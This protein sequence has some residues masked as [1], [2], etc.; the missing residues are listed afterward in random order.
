MMWISYNLKW[1][2]IVNIIELIS[3]YQI[4]GQFLVQ[5]FLIKGEIKGWKNDWH[6]NDYIGGVR[7]LWHLAGSIQTLAYHSRTAIVWAVRAH[8]VYISRDVSRKVLRGMWNILDCLRWILYCT[9]WK[10]ICFFFHFSICSGIIKG[11]VGGR[12]IAQYPP[13]SKY[14]P[15]YIEC[16]FVTE[17]V[18]A[19]SYIT[20]C[21]CIYIRLHNMITLY[22][23]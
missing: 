15:V 14:S 18:C 13:P 5:I 4:Q 16:C 8:F 6:F 22:L 19:S 12:N 21:L 7:T 10:V 17:A 23:L 2:K 9:V 3:I 11:Q 1:V 20:L